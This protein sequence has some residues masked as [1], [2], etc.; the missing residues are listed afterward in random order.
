ML[1]PRVVEVTHD[2][3]LTL[4]STVRSIYD[5]PTMQVG[6]ISDADERYLDRI[7][8]DCESLLGPGIE[9]RGL[10]LATNADQVLR[11]SYRL[12][13]FDGMTEGRGPTLVAAHADLRDNLVIDRITFSLHA[14]MHWG[15]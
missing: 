2:W 6:E 4:E 15:T 7:A 11:L 13:R 9:L 3:F 10:E 5:R 8:E 1:D 14:L 12:G